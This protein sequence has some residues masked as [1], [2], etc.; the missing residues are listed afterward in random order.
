MY[1]SQL[2]IQSAKPASVNIRPSVLLVL[3]AIIS[4][5]PARLVSLLVLVSITQTLIMYANPVMHIALNALDPSRPN[6]HLVSLRM[7][8]QSHPPTAMWSVL[9]V[10]ILI[11]IPGPVLV[12]PLL[13]L[14][15]SYALCH[16]RWS[17]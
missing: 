13:Y 6:A 8:T 17:F 2:A 15:L 5:L 9:L 4:N 14:R 11:T 3:M 12:P 16:L 1:F 7:Y 10:A